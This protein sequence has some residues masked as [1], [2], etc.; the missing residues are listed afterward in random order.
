MEEQAPKAAPA[1]QDYCVMPKHYRASNKPVLLTIND[2]LI[3]ISLIYRLFRGGKLSRRD[4][5]SLVQ[6]LRVIKEIA[7]EGILTDLSAEIL[8]IKEAIDSNNDEVKKNG[9][10]QQSN[11]E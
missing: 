2:I 9:N 1:E 6:A 7:K 3:E 4:F 10:N 8:E 5:S 11:E